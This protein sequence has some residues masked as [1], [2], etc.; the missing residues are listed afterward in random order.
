MTI[1]CEGFTICQEESTGEVCITRNGEEI[2]NVSV[3]SLLTAREL[4]RL[5]RTCLSILR[6]SPRRLGDTTYCDY[7]YDGEEPC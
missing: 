4:E 3:S 7:L 2:L 6:E 1:D 5:F